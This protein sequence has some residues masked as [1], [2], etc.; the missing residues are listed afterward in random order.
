MPTGRCLSSFEPTAPCLLVCF[1]LPPAQSSFCTQRKV[2]APAVPFVGGGSIKAD[3]VR[4]DAVSCAVDHVNV[5]SGPRN[6]DIFPSFYNTNQ[7][8]ISKQ[9]SKA[10]HGAVDICTRTRL[11]SRR[12]D[13]E[14]LPYSSSSSTRI[15]HEQPRLRSMRLAR[16]H[17]VCMC[18][19]QQRD[20]LRGYP[21]LPPVE[22]NEHTNRRKPNTKR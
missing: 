12:L 19:P 9:N 7:H 15:D 18:A 21:C 17:A 22:Q 6:D 20:A 13:L 8:I 14:P 11:T 4:D 5:F 10:Q 16:T 3:V 2:D 1:A